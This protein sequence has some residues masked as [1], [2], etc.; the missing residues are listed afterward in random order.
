ML[1]IS[2]CMMEQTCLL[3]TGLALLLHATQVILGI[4]SFSRDLNILLKML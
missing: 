1:Y 3:L 2:G 4:A